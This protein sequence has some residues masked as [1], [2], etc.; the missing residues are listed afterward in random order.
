MGRR[1]RGMFHRN[2]APVLGLLAVTLAIGA[3]DPMATLREGFE[4]PRP[5]WRQED[6]NVPFRL[7]EH[8]R[9]DH[10]KHGGERSER[11]HFTASGLGSAI[12]YSL[13]LPMVPIVDGLEVSLYSR[14]NQ[15]GVQ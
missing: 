7:I 5:T 8:E 13:P 10:V 4:S 9:T 11:F 1:L 15:T 6:A 2:R 14:S 3:D 12:Y